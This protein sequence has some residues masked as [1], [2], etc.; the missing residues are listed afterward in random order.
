MFSDLTTRTQ[1]SIKVKRLQILFFCQKSLA[2][3][4]NS[5]K[6]Q[7]NELQRILMK[8][9]YGNAKLNKYYLIECVLRNVSF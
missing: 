5:V 3:Q 1:S 4:F 9:Q 8:A 6:T 2:A 7:E